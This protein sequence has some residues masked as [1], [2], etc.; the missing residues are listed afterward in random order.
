MTLNPLSGGRERRSRWRSAK[1]ALS[2]LLSLVV[3]GGV[4]VGGLALERDFR[5][6]F[7]RAAVVPT[8][9]P[10]APAPRPEL[11]PALDF[12][13][14]ETVHP[15]LQGPLRAGVLFDVDTG[16]VLWSRRP[17]A[18][19]PIASLT[20]VT[21]ALLVVERTSPDERAKVTRDALHYSGS[22]VGLLP[23]GRTVTVEALLDGMLLVSGN[24]AA[25]ALAD[26]VA[27]S[28]PAFVDLMNQRAAQL[29]LGCTHF[30]SPHGLEEGNHSC[31]ADLAA[32]ARVAI[33]QPRIARITR[34]AQIAVRFPIKGGK[35]YLNST[36]P[37][38][39]L[40]YPGT[41]GL[42]TGYTQHAGHCY[43]GI[44]RR[45]GRTLGLV[46]LNSR[47][48]GGQAREIFDQAFGVKS[49]DQPAPGGTPPAVPEVAAPP[50]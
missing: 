22:G 3:A 24:D 27:G 45:A 18:V 6:G 50:G 34:H 11:A 16:R 5:H 41:I 43:I 25:L 39:H 42:K 10:P 15:R 28:T 47:D 30:A 29:G 38:L 23:R 49:Q 32:L 36:N 2:M 7:D 17:R 19:L 14:P 35:L 44:V 13:F 26:H 48:T 12:G 33:K 37:L 20:K 4:V 46:L 9:L 1:V 8:A 21:T 40:R 31:A